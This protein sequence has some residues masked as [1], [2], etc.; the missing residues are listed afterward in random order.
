[1]KRTAISML[2]GILIGS[3]ISGG[4]A[5]AVGVMAE[6]SATPIF[7]NGAPVEVEAYAINGNNY[8]KL[9][10]IAELVNFGVFYSESSG[11]V[12]IDTMVGYTPGS[13]PGRKAA[14]S[15][16]TQAQKSMPPYHD[17][18]NSAI[19]D[20]VYTREAYDTLR[21][22]ILNGTDSAETAMSQETYTAM[23]S[24]TAALSSWPACEPR[25]GKNGTRIVVH[26]PESYQEAA[27]Y[28]KPLLDRLSEMDDAQKVRELAFYVCERL[29]YQSDTHAGPGTVLI[30]D[31]ISRGNCMSFAHSFK[32]LCDLAGI[33]CVLVHSDVH[34]WN[35]VYVGGRWQSA[36][37]SG[38][39]NGYHTHKKDDVTVLCRESDLQGIIYHQT[40]TAAANFAKEAL[41]PGSTK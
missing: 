31:A 13:R 27:G 19:F 23:Q 5:L 41:V 34:Q 20:S 12:S 7:L 28:C 14:E 29:D 4:A 26:Y 24:V 32:F 11:I 9:R 17:Q 1:M 38:T 39:D 36:D 33:P 8:M 22:A 25:A 18:A 3:A 10:D 2:I 6:R 21:S 15:T 37:I 40:G 16:T 35:E 30:S